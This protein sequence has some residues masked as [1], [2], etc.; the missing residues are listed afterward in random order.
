MV[1]LDAKQSLDEYVKPYT[2]KEL[3]DL[4]IVKS[5]NTAA[6]TLCDRYP[7]GTTECIRAM[8]VKA[9]VLGM[10]KE[11]C[12]EP[13]TAKCTYGTGAFLLAQLGANPAR[14]S[15]GLTTSVA[16]RLRGL[17]SYCIDGQVYT[18]AAAVRWATNLGLVESAEHLDDTAAASSDGALCV[19]ALAGLAAPWWDSRATATFTGMT[20]STGRGQLVRALLEGIA[21]QVAGLTELIAIDLGQPLMRLR[22]DGGLTRSRVLMQAQA[23]LAQLPIDTYPSPHATALGA[24]ACA[25]LGLD[26]TIDPAQAVGEWVPQHTYEPRWSADQAAEFITRWKRAAHTAL[27][28]RETTTP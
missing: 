23:D 10:P 26:P 22:V 27:S 21:V 6:K 13:G 15:S 8:N 24:A 20:L 28:E 17:T 1:V 4:A 19:P 12:L 25:R 5:D 11:S 3:I 16:W 2:R 14:S 18:A 7:G 9:A